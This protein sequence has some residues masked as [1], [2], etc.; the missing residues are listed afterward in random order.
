LPRLLFGAYRIARMA[1]GDRNPTL[2]ATP[3]GRNFQKLRD[4][5]KSLAAATPESSTARCSAR[6]RARRAL[7]ARAPTPRSS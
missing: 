7:T 1:D 4:E 3:T 2:N 5:L 6:A